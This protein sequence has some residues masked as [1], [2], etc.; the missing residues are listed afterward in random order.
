MPQKI[1]TDNFVF[2]FGSNYA[3]RHGAGA[4]AYAHRYRSAR[5]GTGVGRTGQCYA[6]PT[7]DTKIETLTL[8]QINENVQAFIRYAYANPHLQFQV[9]CIGCGLAG[10]DHAD[11]AP[12]FSNAPA[13]CWFDTLWEPYLPIGS[14]LYWGTF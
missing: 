11:I 4:A 9:T 3:G 2:V 5:M 1:N 6:L 10:L 7:K 14:M 13:N 12:M 8:N